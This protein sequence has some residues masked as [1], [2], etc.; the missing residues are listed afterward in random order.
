MAQK[1]AVFEDLQ[2]ALKIMG[3]VDEK[4]SKSK[5]FHAMW[6]LENKRLQIGININVGFY[7]LN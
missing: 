3:I 2:H 1:N 5:V 6:L 4:T 7:K